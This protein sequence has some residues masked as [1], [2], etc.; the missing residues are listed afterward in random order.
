MC[1]L[2]A[3]HHVLQNDRLIVLVPD[4]RDLPRECQTLVLVRVEVRI[5]R[6][7]V[8]LSK[9][10]VEPRNAVPVVEL[11]LVDGFTNGQGDRACIRAAK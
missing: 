6:I 9:G 7:E 5:Q 1:A 2:N 10:D 8:A 3:A 11:T 4:E